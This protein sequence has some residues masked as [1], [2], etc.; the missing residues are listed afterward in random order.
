MKQLT[1]RRILLVDDDPDILAS[2]ADILEDRGFVVDQALDGLSAIALVERHDYDI[3]LLDFNMPEMDGAE[4]FAQIRSRQ[5]LTVAIMVTAHAADEGVRRALDAGTWK[6]MR[7]PVDVATL[8]AS[9]D[10]ALSQDA[11]LLVDDDKD[12]CNSLWDSL[13]LHGY[14][15]GLAH[16]VSVARKAL[17]SNRYQTVLLDLRLGPDTS[18][19]LLAELSLIPKSPKTI[20]VTGA[21]PNDALVGRLG[22]VGVAAVCHKPVDV[23]QLVDQ[24]DSHA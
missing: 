2:T 22:E 10:D 6:V 7:K 13:R 20:V 21:S 19:G 3:A 1:T 14:R 17:E 5:A 9:I 23:R 12:F 15:V 16:D 8:I 24:I 18:E 4:L 11:V